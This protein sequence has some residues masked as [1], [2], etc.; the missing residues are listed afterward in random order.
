MSES[1]AQTIGRIMD[2]QNGV[3]IYL[4]DDAIN[5]R[6]QRIEELNKIIERPDNWSLLEQTYAKDTKLNYKN[7]HNAIL[8][9]SHVKPLRQI[10]RNFNLN[11][12][13]FTYIHNGKEERKS[14]SGSG[15]IE[16]IVSTGTPYEGS[17]Y[18]GNTYQKFLS[19]DNL[20]PDGFLTLGKSIYMNKELFSF[21]TWELSVYGAVGLV[22][23][24]H[25]EAALVNTLKDTHNQYDMNN[26]ILYCVSKG[27]PSRNGDI[28]VNIHLD[29]STFPKKACV[30]SSDNPNAKLNTSNELTA[31]VNKIIEISE[32]FSEE[33]KHAFRKLF[34]VF[35]VVTLKSKNIMLYYNIL[36][37]LLTRLKFVADRSN[38]K[39]IGMNVDCIEVDGTL[40][41][42]YLSNKLGDFKLVSSSY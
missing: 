10:G 38:C 30:M 6:K 25:V 29:L 1:Y 31:H 40:D 33:I 13:T 22:K 34:T 18:I 41:E 27:I 26:A 39:I 16:F 7:L 42:K 5:L 21:P 9:H 19:K 15:D 32:E 17:L 11:D 8:K 37:T 24:E 23:K 28:P 12:F 14:Y 20:N 36:S 4:D 2:A 35:L 3:N